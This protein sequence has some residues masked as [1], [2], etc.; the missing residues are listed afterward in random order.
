MPALLYIAIWVCIALGFWLLLSGLGKQG[1]SVQDRVSL[2]LL[3]GPLL[4]APGALLLA[5]FGGFS[6]TAIGGLCLTLN[7]ELLRGIQISISAK[8]NK[9]FMKTNYSFIL[10]LR[11][12]IGLFLN[13]ANFLRFQ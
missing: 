3:G 10:F 8:Y 9:L 11:V 12:E 7:S 13:F 4:V 6:A 2:A 1:V 5:D